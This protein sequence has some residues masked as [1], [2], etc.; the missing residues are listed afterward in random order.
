WSLD[1]LGQRDEGLALAGA[2]VHYW[3]VRGYWREGTA[4]VERLL[5][6]SVQGSRSVRA[7]AL[8]A[9]AVLGM[10]LDD[11]TSGGFR[12]AQSL[13]LYKQDGN[14]AGIAN[15]LRV[16]AGIALRSA[17]ARSSSLF[18]NQ[19]LALYRK[20]GDRAGH[21]SALYGLGNVAWITGDYALARERLEES[22]RLRRA[23]DDKRGVAL[24]IN[25][26]GC[27]SLV[28]GN[29]HTGQSLLEKSLEL[30]RD[31]DDRPM[32]AGSLNNL[33]AIAL[34][35]GNYERAQEYADKAIAVWRALVDESDPVLCES[36][37][38]LAESVLNLGNT[39][40]ALELVEKALESASELTNRDTRATLQLTLSYIRFAGG[41]LEQARHA[42]EESLRF[43]RKLGNPISSA[44]AMID[45]ARVAR[46]QGDIHYAFSLTAQACRLFSDAGVVLSFAPCFEQRAAALA[47]I[48]GPVDERRARLLRAVRLWA[49][50]AALREAMGTPIPAF[51]RADYERNLAAARAQLDE[52]TW[53]TAWAEGRAMSLERVIAYA[54]EDTLGD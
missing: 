44:R 23:L 43:F 30:L 22:L 52:A 3:L 26:L 8:L 25:N 49:R 6:D 53:E 18:Y 21:A 12:V 16:A 14:A 35:Q 37:S 5:N 48:N 19:S 54:L 33:A 40:Q 42:C 15:C 34:E 11:L 2:L 29:L 24:A 45:L 10:W 31:L 1:P 4:W 41:Q 39:P 32:V 17:D 27:I 51:E 38:N 28:Q 50:A 46:N 13:A 36:Y 7:K 9:A 47:A 20:L